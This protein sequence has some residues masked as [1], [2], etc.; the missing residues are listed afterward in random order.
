MQISID[1]VARGVLQL[2]ERGLK[3]AE[4][5]CSEDLQIAVDH[6]RDACTLIDIDDGTD[7]EIFPIT[8]SVASPGRSPTSS[9]T[10]AV[11]SSSTLAGGTLGAAE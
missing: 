5:S 10:S 2:V 1:V 3:I 6:D 9:S 4:L 7:G 11:V 8:L